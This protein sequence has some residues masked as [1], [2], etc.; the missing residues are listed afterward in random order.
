MAPGLCTLAALRARNLRRHRLCFVSHKDATQLR[1]ARALPF[2]GSYIAASCGGA[3]GRLCLT[4]PEAADAF[5]SM[6]GQQSFPCLWRS[7]KS[8]TNPKKSG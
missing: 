3:L 4:K 8:R 7:E 5:H 1:N 6:F 2:Q